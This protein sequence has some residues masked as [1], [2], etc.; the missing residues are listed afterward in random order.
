MQFCRLRKYRQFRQNKRHH[1]FLDLWRKI[2]WNFSQ[3]AIFFFSFFDHSRDDTI[4]FLCFVKDGDRQL[5]IVRGEHNWKPGSRTKYFDLPDEASF[6]LAISNS[7]CQPCANALSASSANKANAKKQQLPP[8]FGLKL[9]CPDH[10]MSPCFEQSSRWK[11]LPAP[12]IPEGW[13]P[14]PHLVCFQKLAWMKIE[15]L[16]TK[17]NDLIIL[18]AHRATLY[19]S[20]MI[21]NTSH[22]DFVF[23]TIWLNLVNLSLQVIHCQAAFLPGRAVFTH[24]FS[25]RWRSANVMPAN[26]VISSLSALMSFSQPFHLQAWKLN[27]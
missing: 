18:S 26:L 4:D 16:C 2:P 24:R 23:S 12:W 19:Y 25:L 27:V 3:L 9:F 5:F 22:S 14:I 13:S 20:K 7:S 15:L 17:E 1:H 11:P 8:P 10:F 6:C 21:K